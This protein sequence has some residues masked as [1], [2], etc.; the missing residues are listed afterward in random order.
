ML[1]GPQ[2]L[3]REIEQALRRPGVASDFAH[4]FSVGMGPS[5][6]RSLTQVVAQGVVPALNQSIAGA[7]DS[8]LV[9]VHQE[10]V[11]VRK[12]IEREQSE[13]V[14]VLEEEVGALR[15]DVRDLKAALERMENLVLSLS[16]RNAPPAVVSPQARQSTLVAQQ[17]PHPSVIVP[18]AASYTLPPVPRSQTPPQ[19]YEE[20]F[21]HVLQPQHEPHFTGLVQFI[22]SLPPTRMDA[23]FPPPPASPRI[24]APIVLS[25]CYRLSQVLATAHELQPLD[26][27]ARKALHWIRK[28]L[29]AIDKVSIFSSYLWTYLVNAADARLVSFQS[30]TP[31]VASF[32]P[33]ILDS[34]IT[35]LHARGKALIKLNDR[36]GAEEIRIV[37]QYARAQ[38][39]V[40]SQGGPAQWR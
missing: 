7:I 8:I 11:T 9:T 20:L 23:V 32:T 39:N 2:T 27:D 10:M 30:Q 35:S 24:S 16:S 40:V 29:S 14:V 4:S 28:S 19:Q 13:A 37:E 26:D 15:G 21:T 5:L 18:P 33:R 1:M 38:L 25:L 34:V 12:E 31:E 3:P 17:Q 6:E 22:R 36:R